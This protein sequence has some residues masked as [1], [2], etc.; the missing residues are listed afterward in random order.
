MIKQKTIDDLIKTIT[1]CKGEYAFLIG[2]GTSKSAGIPT[3]SGLIE[4]WQ[5]EAYSREKTEEN[6]EGWVSKK[7]RS[8]NET[9]NA[10]GFWFEE[11]YTTK[12][13]RRKYIEN[14]VVSGADPQFGH[15]VLASM[16]TNDYG[17]KYVPVT[18]TPNFDD[19]LYDAFY[20]Y[21]E[22]RPLLINHNAIATQFTLTRDSPTIVKVHGDYLYENVK[23][24]GSETKDL[25]ENIADILTQTIGEYGLVVVGYS[26][27]D[28]SLMKP[29]LEANRSDAG[30]F[31]CTRSVDDVSEYT[32]KL[33]H[34]PNVFH[35]EIEGF[36]ELFSK[37]YT[38]V[39]G[40]TAP[41]EHKLME[42]AHSRAIS[43]SEKRQEAMKHAPEEE[44]KKF[45]ISN[46][47]AKAYSAF[48]SEKYEEAS[49]ILDDVLDEE[50]TNGDLPQIFS[51]A[52][53]LYAR[54]LNEGFDEP[55]RAKNHF[56]KALEIDPEDPPVHN[57]YA[58]ILFNKLEEP[59]KSQK[60]FEKS[61]EL[62]PENH[63]AHGN[64]AKLLRD[65]L[66]QPEKAEEHYQRAL[67]LNS[68]HY[69]H[70]SNYADLLGNQ[71]DQPQAAQK[72]Y[73]RALEL[74]PDDVSTHT[75]YAELL[76][77]EIGDLEKSEEHYQT[78][79]RIDSNDV[80]GNLHYADLLSNEL[81]NPE[82]SKDYYKAALESD[83]R[84]SEAHRKYATLLWEKL[85]E[86]Q[87]AEDHFKES[88]DIKPDCAK[89]H[90]EY[91][92]FLSSEGEEQRAEKHYK[93]AA[94]LDSEYD[95]WT[96]D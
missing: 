62:N 80:S 14:Q 31:W 25:E 77:E 33:L 15:I 40:L 71:L 30:I 59:E 49:N 53:S 89:T 57:N 21:I 4:N 45:D 93:R 19:L 38:R 5:K 48:N 84:N 1:E 2:A 41:Q 72:H 51:R 24:L 20:H 12:R 86:E 26:G 76:S 36:E 13:Q 79:L 55:E 27:L 7:E 44:Q 63:S 67:D 28:N 58:H 91:A 3:A 60:H 11:V 70:H 52:H 85:N 65:E 37:I 69:A 8:I 66:E 23:N 64:Y 78:A 47:I 95:D 56:K 46:S 75:K 68:E 18:L 43:L 35:V 6:F 94:E 17:E 32:E 73:E 74:N 81:N 82:E 22:Q 92:Q 61:L 16:M 90:Y 39:D 54:I 87:E 88:L 96:E 9:Q 29:L 83:P 50:E 42:R 10:Y 34:Q